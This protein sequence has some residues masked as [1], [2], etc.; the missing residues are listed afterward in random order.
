MKQRIQFLLVC[1]AALMALTAGRAQAQTLFTITFTPS[2]VSGNPGDL[3]FYSGTF[4]NTSATDYF[5]TGASF[6]STSLNSGLLASFFN[7]DPVSGDPSTGA[8]EVLANTSQTIS[9]VFAL[10]LDPMQPT[11]TYNGFAT[12][13][14]QTAMDYPNGTDGELGSA[15]LTLTVPAAAPEASSLIGFSLLLALGGFRLLWPKRQAGR[16]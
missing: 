16:V 3:I 13:T 11:G 14:G 10:Q 4:A 2:A 6:D 12:F 8:F 7:G 1:L 15:A 5:V 9:S